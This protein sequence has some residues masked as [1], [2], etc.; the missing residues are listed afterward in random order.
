MNC[1]QNCW[2]R[3][4]RGPAPES[5]NSECLERNNLFYTKFG[6][7]VCMKACKGAGLESQ[8][9][10]ST[11]CSWSTEGSAPTDCWGESSCLTQAPVG[12]LGDPL[13]NSLWAVPGAATLRPGVG[14]GELFLKKFPG[15][16]CGGSTHFSNPFPEFP[17]AEDGPKASCL[18]GEHS[19]SGLCPHS[20]LVGA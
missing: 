1:Q 19:I 12:V 5:A 13:K 15:V 11:N 6:E 7:S 20:P 10:V 4:N 16:S 18:L 9:S 3:G 2:L 8:F 14:S 17:S